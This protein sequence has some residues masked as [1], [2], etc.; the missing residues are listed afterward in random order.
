MTDRMQS[1]KWM[2]MGNYNVILV[3]ITDEGPA[4]RSPRE[5]HRRV[6]HA[7]LHPHRV[8]SKGQPPGHLGERPYQAGLDVQ[9]L[10]YARHREG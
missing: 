6:H 2:R 10:T 5:V 3:R 1:V 4:S 8:L 9:I 7:L